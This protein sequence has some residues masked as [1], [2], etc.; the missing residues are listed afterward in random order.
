MPY[1]LLQSPVR[2]AGGAGA[3]GMAGAADAPPV[4]GLP[5]DTPGTSLQER[6][7]QTRQVGLCHV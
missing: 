4:V 7:G 6:P 1:S 3:A 2:P 5:H